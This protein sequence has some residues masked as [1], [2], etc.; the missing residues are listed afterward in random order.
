MLVSTALVDHVV[1]VP[2]QDLL[3][4]QREPRR[5][6]RLQHRLRGLEG[7]AV[8]QR[9]LLE[10]DRGQLLPHPVRARLGRREVQRALEDVLVVGGRPVVVGQVPARLP[11]QRS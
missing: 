3:V 5:P 6:P 1:Q 11:D 7:V 4:T 9:E 10:R 2:Q 8:L